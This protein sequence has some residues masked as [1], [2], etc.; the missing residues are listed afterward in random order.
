LQLRQTTRQLIGFAEQESGYPVEVVHD[1]PPTR[2]CD[3]T[4]PTWS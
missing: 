2:R 1:R 3:S 4:R